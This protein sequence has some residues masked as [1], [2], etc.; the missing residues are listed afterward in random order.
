MLP[1]SILSGTAVERIAFDF[2]DSI[3]NVQRLADE[4]MTRERANLDAPDPCRAPLGTSITTEV[5]V[6]GVFL[7][8][9]AGFAPQPPSRDARYRWK[10]DD[11]TEFTLSHGPIGVASHGEGGMISSHCTLAIS[12]REAHI[13]VMNATAGGAPDLRIVA[14]FPKFPEVYGLTFEGRAASQERQRDLLAIVRTISIGH[15]WGEVG[16]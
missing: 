2:G 8:L 14:R 10:A 6:S 7:A 13:D 12:G 15:I 5:V 3:N 4:R 1:N 9:P 11:G 16:R